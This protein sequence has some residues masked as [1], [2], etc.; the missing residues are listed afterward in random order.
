MLTNDR[1]TY[2]VSLSVVE[3]TSASVQAEAFSRAYADGDEDAAIRIVIAA[4]EA[5]TPFAPPFESLW[6]LCGELLNRRRYRLGLELTECVGKHGYRGWRSLYLRGIFLALT[7]E[8]EPAA[9]VFDSARRIAPVKKQGE[10]AL[11]EGRLRAMAG[12]TAIALR[13]FR[14]NLRFDEAGERF[15]AAA[16]RI[17]HREGERD[18]VV[19]WAE[20]ANAALGVTASRMRLL[21][22]I[23]YESGEWQKARD[24]AERGTRIDP[25]NV[26][27]CR[28]VARS[29]YREGRVAPAIMQLQAQLGR[30]GEWTEASPLSLAHCRPP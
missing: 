12:Q 5:G 17:A 13:L 10:I 23:H 4:F 1:R 11:L 30:D 9:E 6:W 22:E 14:E 28:I 26:V 2:P 19:R 20:Q 18:L 8:I 15:V 16:L 24:A 27:L 3:H 7:R 29:A 21:A 25:K